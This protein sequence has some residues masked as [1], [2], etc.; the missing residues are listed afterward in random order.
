MFHSFR[1]N[2]FHIGIK[3]SSK[4]LS[5]I[6]LSAWFLYDGPVLGLCFL[7]WQLVCDFTCYFPLSIFYYEETSFS[8]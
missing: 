3:F 2:E 4:N 1:G 6:L 5:Q 7:K 8:C